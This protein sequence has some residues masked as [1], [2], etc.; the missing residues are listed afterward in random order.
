MA[1][2][3]PR[4]RW[5]EQRRAELH[6]RFHPDLAQGDLEGFAL[7]RPDGT[8]TAEVVHVQWLDDHPAGPDTHVTVSFADGTNVR[9]TFDLPVVKVRTADLRTTSR[10]DVGEAAPPGWG[11]DAGRWD[12]G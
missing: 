3:D 8:L 11:A 6:R 2:T 9:F 12:V 7:V 5:R 4:R 10:D 1:D